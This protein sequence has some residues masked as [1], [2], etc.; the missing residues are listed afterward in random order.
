MGLFLLVSVILTSFICFILL[1]SVIRKKSNHSV[2]LPSEVNKFF[3]KKNLH[4]F[5]KEIEAGLVGEKKKLIVELKQ[6][7]LDNIVKIKSD[8]QKSLTPSFSITMFSLSIILM[9]ICSYVVYMKFG[10]FYKVL[11]WKDVSSK[12]PELSNKLILSEKIVLTKD[13]RLDL[14]LALRTR[15]HYQPADSLGWLLLGLIG[16]ANQDINMA[17]LA[18]KKA[19]SLEPENPNIQRGYAQALIFSKNI[20]EKN[21]AYRILDTLEK[22]Q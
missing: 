10:A 5:E 19:Y 17:I 7:F 21:K 11:H 1:F 8:E 20:V 16:L 6:S 14:I 22:K 2:L 18:M 15:L 9:V 13:E 12:L 3:Y 4:E